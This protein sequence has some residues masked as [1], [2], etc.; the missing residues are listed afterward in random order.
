[1]TSAHPDQAGVMADLVRGAGPRR[2]ERHG[3]DGDSTPFGYALP[4]RGGASPS[5]AQRSICV[6]PRR[7]AAR[8]RP[9]AR[10]TRR[11]GAARR[12]AS[13]AATGADGQDEALLAACRARQAAI[14][15]YLA[16]TGARLDVRG[17]QGMTALHE[18]VWRCDHATVRMLLDRGA[19]LEVKNELRWH[20]A[21][22][23]HVGDSPPAGQ[24]PRLAAA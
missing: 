15:A 6:P 2:R 22:L 7:S 9:R 1:V 14:A 13:P 12:A 20:R 18:A 24:S 21:R 19:P 5:A 11:G 8:P 17:N 16:D 3:P 10:H 23:R 4:S